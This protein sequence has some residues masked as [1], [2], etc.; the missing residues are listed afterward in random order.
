MIKIIVQVLSGLWTGPVLVPTCAQQLQM[1]W[2]ET[3]IST[4]HMIRDWL[5]NAPGEGFLN[6]PEKK[7]K[8]LLFCD[9]FSLSL[10]QVENFLSCWVHN[11]WFLRH[12]YH[13]LSVFFSSKI[14]SLCATLLLLLLGENYLASPNSWC[15]G[16]E[17]RSFHSGGGSQYVHRSPWVPFLLFLFF[18]S[19]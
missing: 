5:E 16:I 3:C 9:L 15:M 2:L 19:R 10:Y 11:R 8:S 13:S 17:R 14:A 18:K 4:D 6:F 1:D 12:R 7:K